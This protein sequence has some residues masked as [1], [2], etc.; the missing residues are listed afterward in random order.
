MINLHNLYL[1]NYFVIVALAYWNAWFSWICELLYLALW[2]AYSL[3]LVGRTWGGYDSTTFLWCRTIAKSI[4]LPYWEFILDGKSQWHPPTVLAKRITY[5]TT[6]GIG[7][8][9]SGKLQHL[10]QSWLQH[11]PGLIDALLCLAEPLPDCAGEPAV[12][13]NM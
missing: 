2:L 6:G 10:F 1:T 11:W 9:L 7:Y 4:L 12:A 13:N 5:I 8:E 3:D